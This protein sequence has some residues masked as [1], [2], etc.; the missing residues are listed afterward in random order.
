MIN[1]KQTAQKNHRIEKNA[2][3]ALRTIYGKKV[4]NQLRVK[5]L[6]KMVA[7]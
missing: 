1:N 6:L 5:E 4:Y 3:K 2:E 7:V